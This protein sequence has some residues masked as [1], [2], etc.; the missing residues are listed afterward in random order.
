EV[1]VVEVL[2]QVVVEV[3][4]VVVLVVLFVVVEFLI[5][6][7]GTGDQHFSRRA[8]PPGDRRVGLR[9]GAREGPGC[10]TEHECILGHEGN[11]NEGGGELA[12]CLSANRVGFF[13]R[14]PPGSVAVTAVSI[15]WRN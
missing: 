2:V 7:C 1:L 4:V 5:L 13:S 15:R 10:A 3:L 8:V 11:N 9:G 12:V 6:L 14:T